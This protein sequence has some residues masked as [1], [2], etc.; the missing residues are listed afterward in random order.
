MKE[1]RLK[2]A[3]HNI[4]SDASM[5][6]RITEK[7][8]HYNTTPHQSRKIPVFS[9]LPKAAAAVLIFIIL[10]TTT[11]F[12]A[13][14]FIKSYKVKYSHIQLSDEILDKLT[15][16]KAIK[17]F[18]SGHKNEYKT[19]YDPEGNVTSCIQP[20]D[21]D[22]ED[23][24]YGDEAFAYIGLP[25]LVPTYLYDHYLL[26]EGGYK[27]AET[28]LD[29]GTVLKQLFASFFYVK[30]SKRVYLQYFP[31]ETSTKNLLNYLTDNTRKKSDFINETYTAKSGLICNLR[32]DKKNNLI[33][34]TIQFDSNSIGN[35]SY[36]L[37]FCDIQMEEA[38]DILDSI[39][40]TEKV[41]QDE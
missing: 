8:I 6:Q 37:C 15:P 41:I 35:A 25:N 32:K 23:M 21:Q 28:K 12:A 40:V 31:S 33:S 26:T 10:G 1:S 13:G 9:F 16:V 27:Y 19:T 11:A 18:G 5:D 22:K 34:V 7:L 24:K 2:E 4:D 14:Y 20:E 38:K 29:D 17:S 36:Y 39:P 30:S 3:M